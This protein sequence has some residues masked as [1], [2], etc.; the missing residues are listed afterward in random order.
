MFTALP[1]SKRGRRIMP[2]VEQKTIYP[3][4][5]GEYKE[6]QGEKRHKPGG[7]RSS[8]RSISN[9]RPSSGIWQVQP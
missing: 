3:K 6:S 1:F 7:V 5:S 2:N 4:G 8:E 9:L